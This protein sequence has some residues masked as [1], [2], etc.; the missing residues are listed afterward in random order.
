MFDEGQHPRDDGGKFTDKGGGSRENYTRSVNDRIKWA[1]ENGVDLPLNTDG[2]VDD[3]KLQELYEK[4]KDRKANAPAEDKTTI[5]EQVKAGLE[6]I[7]GTKILLEI[8]KG[9]IITD[10]QTAATTL[11]MELEKTG[12]VVSREGFGDVQVSSRLKQAAAY[13]KSPAEIAAISTVPTI[14]QKGVLIGVHKNHKGREYASFTFAGKV[15]IEEQEGI[16]AV[17]VKKTTG[18]FY[19]V[20]RVLTPDG[21]DLKIENDTD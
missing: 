20:H 13:V 3:L 15:S 1:K 4:G 6:K 21:K 12:G 8:P 18:N 5:K 14:I 17:V 7:E 19:K 2:S 11:R 9:K 16:I 10:F